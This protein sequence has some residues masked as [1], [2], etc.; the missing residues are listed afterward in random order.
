MCDLSDK[1]KMDVA[2]KTDYPGNPY[3]HYSRVFHNPPNSQYK[4]CAEEG[5]NCNYSG[6]VRIAYGVN[7]IFNY[8]TVTS[9]ETSPGNYA[10]TSVRCDNQKFGDSVPGFPKRCYI[11]ATSPGSSSGAITGR[12]V[13]I[14]RYQNGKYRQ[15]SNGKTWAEAG[16]NNA[17]RSRLTETGRDDWNVYL[18]KSDGATIQLDLQNKVIK[19]NG[20]TIYKI[21]S[22]WAP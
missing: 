20:R 4:F 15:I 21:T 11:L 14:V 22:V 2:L 5:Q 18:R 1:S 12:N 13:K 8:K 9:R 7:G 10:A 6:R 16:N 19:L 3:D 17:E